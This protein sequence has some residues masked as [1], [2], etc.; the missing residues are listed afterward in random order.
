M[1]PT[2]QFPGGQTDAE[3]QILV[4]A[5]GKFALAMMVTAI[6]QRDNM[7]DEAVAA[8]G[9]VIQNWVAV[10]GEFLPVKDIA[11]EMFP[12]AA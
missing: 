11:E 2:T 5:L 9:Q 7:S 6:Q 4:D 12:E 10:A 3:A 1:E 8:F